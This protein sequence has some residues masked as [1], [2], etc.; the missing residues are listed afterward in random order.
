MSI[1]QFFFVKKAAK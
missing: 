1:A